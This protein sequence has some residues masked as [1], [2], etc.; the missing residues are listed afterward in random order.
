MEYDVSDCHKN[1]LLRESGIHC[2]SMLEFFTAMR[3]KNL[4]LGGGGHATKRQ[5][6]A[7]SNMTLREARD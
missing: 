7:H 1:I 2:F 5:P 4:A 6:C 3:P